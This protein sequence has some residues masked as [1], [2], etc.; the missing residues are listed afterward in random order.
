MRHRGPDDS[1][2]FSDGEVA[3]GFRRL[4]IIDLSGGHQPLSTSCGRY[5]IVFNGEIYNYRELREEL[6]RD[7]RALFRTASDT[8]VVVNA[9]KHW[10]TDAL[11]RFNGMFAFAVWDA[12][13]RSLLLAR[14]RIGKKPLFYSVSQHGIVFASEVKS[15]LD[16][17]DVPRALDTSR[18]PTFLAYRYVPGDETLFA[19][20]YCL[21]AGTWAHVSAADV[22]VTPRTY[23]DFSFRNAVPEPTVPRE[24]RDITR[25]CSPTA[26]D[27]RCS[28]R[29]VPVGRT[30][31]V[32]SSR[33]DGPPC[34]CTREDLFDR[35]H[36]W[37]QRG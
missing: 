27:R 11:S 22:R 29:I 14:D 17:P 33:I 5:T 10:G 1:G 2:R 23:W 26:D 36:H 34:I 8:E 4:S 25:R 6:V 19:G 15:L 12:H 21:P 9:V 31:F 20:V 7:C 28:S 13:V 35:F 30:R 37:I 18:L 32:N 3:L 16:H 24:P